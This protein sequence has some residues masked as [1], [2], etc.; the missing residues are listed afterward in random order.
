M[1]NH[2]DDSSCKELL[3]K[4]LQL[5]DAGAYSIKLR[6]QRKYNHISLNNTNRK[7]TVYFLISKAPLR[8][9]DHPSPD[10]TKKT[11]FQ[12]LSHHSQVKQPSSSACW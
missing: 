11:R 12:L 7:T 6:L 4:R 2:A 1:L 3:R 10:D 9:T 8:V 5:Q